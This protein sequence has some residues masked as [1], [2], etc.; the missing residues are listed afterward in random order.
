MELCKKATA[1]AGLQSHL[2]HP[3]LVAEV[4]IRTEVADE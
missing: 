4:L 3:L 1:A 2:M